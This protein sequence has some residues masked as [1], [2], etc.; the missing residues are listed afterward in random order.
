MSV[1]VDANNTVVRDGE[2]QWAFDIDCR[3]GSA[4]IA[5][6]GDHYVVRPLAWREKCNLARFSHLGESFLQT[7]FLR[8]SLDHGDLPPAENSRAALSAL[9]RWINAPDGN[10]GLPLDQQVLA[11]VTL[12]ICNSLQLAPAA[13]HAL[14]A[15]EI[16]MLWQTSRTRQALTPKATAINTSHADMPMGT[17]RIVVVPD[18]DDGNQKPDS[19]PAAEPRKFNL[20]TDLVKNSGQA[21]QVQASSEPDIA[22][23]VDYANF[24]ALEKDTLSAPTSSTPSVSAAI[25]A[26]TKVT[27][28][29]VNNSPVNSHF[30]N[31]RANVKTAPT[32]STPRSLHDAGAQARFRVDFSHAPT[33]DLDAT[34]NILRAT[35]SAAIQLEQTPQFTRAVDRVIDESAADAAMSAAAPTAEISASRALIREKPILAFPHGSSLHKQ[36]NNSDLV[37]STQNQ[38]SLLTKNDSPPDSSNRQMATLVDH[39]LA[40]FSTRLDE[41]ARAAGIDLEN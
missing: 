4:R 22:S 11:E 19:I 38:S 16:E 24:D 33:A 13:F 17:T 35:H 39:C 31:P 41:A 40:A 2:Q 28:S 23:T 6:E 32:N 26:S 10:F 14:A 36:A 15:N 3:D 25:R 12:D 9:A 20:N 37:S 27:T 8:A 1:Y 30:S 29:R 21:K 5:L 18:A 7:Q 34:S